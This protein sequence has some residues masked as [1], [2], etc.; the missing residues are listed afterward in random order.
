MKEKSQGT[1]RERMQEMYRGTQQQCMQE[2]SKELGKNYEIKE[3][4]TMQ[5]VFKRSRKELGKK[6]CKKTSEKTR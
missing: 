2:G 5:I 3:E 1:W 6:V 4:G